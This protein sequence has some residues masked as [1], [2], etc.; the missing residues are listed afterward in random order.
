MNMQVREF[1]ALMRELYLD[2]DSN[3]G[4]ERTLLWLVEEVGELSEALRKRDG[5][6]MEE[7]LADIIA[8]TMSLAN[9]LGID[10]EEALMDKYPGYCRYCK[11]SP[12]ACKK[13]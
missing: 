13:K 5:G 12:C 6:A 10:M 11:E 3:R 8:W 2:K 4:A 7:E 9:V 1:Q